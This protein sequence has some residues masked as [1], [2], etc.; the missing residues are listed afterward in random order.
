MTGVVGGVMRD[1]ICNE[2]PYV[3]QRTELY[4]TCAFAG[5]WSY[6]LVIGTAGD[7]LTAVMGCI[8]ITF[9]LRML[10]IRY[11]IRLPI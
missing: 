8:T 5:A 9:V 10:A 2:I 4:A 1:I 7:E 6:L 11:K 3:F